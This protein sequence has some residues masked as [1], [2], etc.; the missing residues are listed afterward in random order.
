RLLDLEFS[1]RDLVRAVRLS[2]L[3]GLP[4]SGRSVVV[5]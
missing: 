4:G 5:I 1:L 2:F 3:A